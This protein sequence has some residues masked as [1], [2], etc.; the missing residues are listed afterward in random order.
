[1]ADLPRLVLSKFPGKSDMDDFSVRVGARCVHSC[2]PSIAVIARACIE[3]LI[4]V[5]AAELLSLEVCSHAFL[6]RMVR[7]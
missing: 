6:E 1:M 2:K 5:S 4:V 3:G 7:R